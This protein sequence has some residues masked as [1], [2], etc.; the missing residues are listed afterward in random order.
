MPDRIV[1]GINGPRG[2][3][4][5]AAAFLCILHGIAYT[6]L[7]GGPDELPVGLTA[8]GEV[9]PLW[10]YGV[11]WFVAGGVALAGAFVGRNGRQRD[12]ADSWGFGTAVGMF[13]AWGLAYFCGWGLTLSQGGQS[14]SWISG[15]LYITVAIIVSA[16]ARMTN[17]TRGKRGDQ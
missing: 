10:L 13:V 14:R 5:L 3:A 7:T 1:R 4:L 16:A 11:S 9:V 8:L 15:S 17:P 2:S 6:P 12:S